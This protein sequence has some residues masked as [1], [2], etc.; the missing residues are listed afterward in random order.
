M[1]YEVDDRTLRLIK[2]TLLYLIGII[3][4]IAAF[5]GSLIGLVYLFGPHAAWIY[6][7]VLFLIWPS[8]VLAKSKLKKL[9]EKER[10]IERELRKDW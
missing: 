4:A 7:L 8:T 1:P 3:A 2:I 9:E 5:A 6:L 10:R